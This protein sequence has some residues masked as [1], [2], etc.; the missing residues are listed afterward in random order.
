MNN[1][2]LILAG[3]TL[4]LLYTSSVVTS[5]TALNVTNTTVTKT[6][7]NAT[8]FLENGTNISQPLTPL[9]APEVNITTMTNITGTNITA[10]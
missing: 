8:V 4:A 5:A 1:Y 3:I 7:A 9:L 6:P 10:R 2:F